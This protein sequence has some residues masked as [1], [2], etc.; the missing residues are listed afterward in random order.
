MSVYLMNLAPAD[1]PLALNFHFSRVIKN[2]FSEGGAP[3]KEGQGCSWH[4]LVLK[5][6]DVLPHRVFDFRRSHSR[7]FRG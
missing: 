7:S 4:L 6:A 3:I 2:N 5:N 1:F